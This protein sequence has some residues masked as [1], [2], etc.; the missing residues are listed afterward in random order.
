MMMMVIMSVLGRGML[1]YVRGCC[2]LGGMSGLRLIR[3]CVNRRAD[4]CAHESP[5]WLVSFLDVC[6]NVWFVTR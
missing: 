4:V 2:V 3:Q 6:V 5:G 1:W